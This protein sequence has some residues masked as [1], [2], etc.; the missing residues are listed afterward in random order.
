MGLDDSNDWFVGPTFKEWKYEP[1]PSVS[2]EIQDVISK[3]RGIFPNAIVFKDT[4]K[5]TNHV[6][7]LKLY[8]VGE[9]T[10]ITSEELLMITGDYQ[11]VN[12]HF[13]LK[14]RWSETID[15]A[16]ISTWVMIQQIMLQKFEK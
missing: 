6:H 9:P 11:R 4:H 7:A 10:L 3:V 2:T 13:R 12:S 14:G 16:W 5:Y 8:G 1:M 15:E